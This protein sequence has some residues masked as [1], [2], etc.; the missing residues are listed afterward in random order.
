[1][2][3]SMP[4]SNIYGGTNSVSSRSRS[5]SSLDGGFKGSHSSHATLSTSTAQEM[6]NSNSS[7]STR[8]G[9]SS[10][11]ARKMHRGSFRRTLML[12]KSKRKKNNN[13]ANSETRDLLS[14]AKRTD[15]SDSLSPASAANR[16]L[17]GRSGNRF[18]VNR[19]A[20]RNNVGKAVVSPA[21][22]EREA[23][24][25][26]PTFSRP[27][28][29]N[30]TNNDGSSSSH[31]PMTSQKGE[32]IPQGHI[33]T[34]FRFYGGDN[35][36]EASLDLY[37][38]VL[39]VAPNASDRE[40][41]IAYFRRGR[42]ILGENAANLNPKETTNKLDN[43]TKARFQAVSMVYEILSKP[44]WKETYMKQ[45]GLRRRDNIG[46]NV[47][48]KNEVPRSARTRLSIRDSSNLSEIDPC[49]SSH[50]A[51]TAA[52]PNSHNSDH[53][54][55]IQREDAGRLMALQENN[56]NAHQRQNQSTQR[57]P[58]ALRKSSFVGKGPYRM[59]KSSTERSSSSV[60]WK[61]HVE[62]LIFA[63]HPNEHDPNEDDIDGEDDILDQ[64]YRIGGRQTGEA[65]NGSKQT[66]QF[67]NSPFP[68]GTNNSNIRDDGTNESHGGSSRS[69][70]R[71]K[72]K[73]RIVIDSEELE[74]HLRRMDN[75]AEKH[76]V[77]DFWDNFEESMDGILSLVDSIGGGGRDS[78]KASNNKHSGKS[79]FTT[80]P[81]STATP[82]LTS[83][84]S[85]M[86]SS[87]SYR[88]D[89]S[90]RNQ[91]EADATIGRSSSHDMTDTSKSIKEDIS[92]SDG[93]VKRSSSFP[94]PGS[95]PSTVDLTSHSP[96]SLKINQSESSYRF[97][98][99][100]DEK[101]RL[102]GQNIT[103]LRVSSPYERS[104]NSRSFQSTK[105]E[106]ENDEQ[107]NLQ[108]PEKSS[109]VIISPSPKSETATTSIKSKRELRPPNDLD[110]TTTS[111]ASSILSTSPRRQQY[112]RPISPAPSEASD[113]FSTSLSK[114]KDAC[115]SMHSQAESDKF[116][117]ESRL[118]EMDSIDLTA[119][120]NPFRNE[121]PPS[122]S[123]P[124]V[125][126]VVSMP[127]LSNN[128]C[129]ESKSTKSSDRVEKKK[130]R[131]K[132]SM[133]SK[134]GENSTTT[135]VSSPHNT[136]PADK[137]SVCNGTSTND[138]SMEDVFAGVEE[139]SQP[140]QQCDTVGDSK[141][142]VRDISIERS[143]SHMSD[144]SG[145]IHSTRRENSSGG[146]ALDYR[147][148]ANPSATNIASESTILTLDPSMTTVTSSVLSSSTKKSFVNS[149]VGR[150]QG[151]TAFSS[152]NSTARDEMKSV[153]TMES[154]EVE[155]SGFFEYFATYA[156]AVMA[157]CANLGAAAGTSEYHKDF[158]N[159]FTND[160]ST[161][162]PEIREQPSAMHN[163]PSM[164]T[165]G[166]A[167]C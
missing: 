102:S 54:K 144:L 58:T 91:D 142:K 109:P 32:E 140:L 117:L 141:L 2:V 96:Q 149:S 5:S 25:D 73:Q 64:N 43:V 9:S 35:K 80:L 167:S 33:D 81:F 134:I 87:E 131:F 139:D 123:S 161:N 44:S 55:K 90:Q 122:A 20:F 71:K 68:P 154:M 37:R 86:S 82:W 159:L 53:G 127:I 62:E 83:A 26:S 116:E 52:F 133:V 113:L 60:R 3:Y 72:N 78:L 16:I 45:G 38:D 24:G 36:T 146:K 162:S 151:S 50:S 49:S 39:R 17:N 63:N 132:V 22:E 74:S 19:R 76:F 94:L 51:V 147:P 48:R 121:K 101:D 89:R 135:E 30:T 23:G 112:F 27:N 130:N 79:P 85:M 129:A 41:R 126:P 136:V 164:S 8:S 107:I 160:P 47:V 108:T 65:C 70:R 97:L 150:S 104:V 163:T 155:T 115:G 31:F 66:D 118:S 165:R 143:V 145:S 11:S 18:Q 56:K 95:S 100:P 59:T 152:Y 111:V 137:G 119:L 156:T 67:F 88:H 15:V 13:A 114:R 21:V 69:R 120:E 92:N 99:S 75:E 12:Q 148:K 138:E 110:A 10:S 7:R 166:T 61:D 4:S 128:S 57:L 105:I 103:D 34:I 124:A 125:E 42:E 93:P 106:K 98:V 77:K 158:L 6:E 153:H 46:T 28:V 1:M 14:G 84:T 157:E 29:S 40:V